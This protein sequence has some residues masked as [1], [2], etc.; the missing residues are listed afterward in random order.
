MH[1]LQLLAGEVLRRPIEFTLTALVRVVDDA[2]RRS[3]CDRHVERFDDEVREQ[4]ILHRPTHDLAAPRVQ[5]H[6]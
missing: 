5:D 6:R 4:V 2:L 3:L 1:P